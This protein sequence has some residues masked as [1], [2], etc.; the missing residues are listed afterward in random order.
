MSFLF[1][2]H[3]NE[4]T[5]TEEEQSVLFPQVPQVPQV[6]KV[7]IPQSQNV[8]PQ[9]GVP[10]CVSPKMQVIPA[11][12]DKMIQEGQ[13]LYIL[14]NKE[15]YWLPK[16][17][18]LSESVAEKIPYQAAGESLYKIPECISPKMSSDGQLNDVQPKKTGM[19]RR[20]ANGAGKALRV[21]GSIVKNTAGAA[22]TVAE[23]AG[24]AAFVGVG[25][26]VMA[27]CG[28]G[29]PQEQKRLSQGEQDSLAKVPQAHTNQLMEEPQIP[30][31]QEPQ[32]QEQNVQIVSVPQN[33]VDLVQAP[34]NQEPQPVKDGEMSKGF[35]GLVKDVIQSVS[36]IT[37]IV[38]WI[39]EEL[40]NISQILKPM[41]QSG[42]LKIIIK[43]FGTIGPIAKELDNIGNIVDNSIKLINKNISIDTKDVMHYEPVL[44]NA[45]NDVADDDIFGM[46]QKTKVS[47]SI[48]AS[49]FLKAF[50]DIRNKYKATLNKSWFSW[51][52]VANMSSLFIG[53]CKDLNPCVNKY[54]NFFEY[55]S[56]G[57]LS[58]K[59]N[60]K[61]L[62]C[63]IYTAQYIIN[64]VATIPCSSFKVAN[65][66]RLVKVL[67]GDSTINYNHVNYWDY[68]EKEDEN[69]PINDQKG[70]NIKIG[71]IYEQKGTADFP[72]ECGNEITDDLLRQKWYIDC[73]TSKHSL[74]FKDARIKIN[75]GNKDFEKLPYVVV[76]PKVVNRS[77]F[78]DVFSKY[79]FNDINS[80]EY[81]IGENNDVFK[82]S[83]KYV[84]RKIIDIY[85]GAY[86]QVLRWEIIKKLQNQNAGDS[87]S[88]YYEKFYS[89]IFKEIIEHSLI[90]QGVYNNVYSADSKV[91]GDIYPSEH[92]KNLYEDIVKTSNLGNKIK[93]NFAELKI[94]D[95]F[96]DMGNNKLK[97]IT[98]SGKLISDLLN[99][100]SSL[101]KHSSLMNQNYQ[102]T[103]ANPE[104]ISS[105]QKY[106]GQNLAFVVKSMAD[107]A[108]NIQAVMQHKV[109]SPKNG[110]G[111][112]DELF[113]GLA[114]LGA[115]AL[116]KY[117]KQNAENI[118]I[119]AN[120][121]V[122][123][124]DNMPQIIE[125]ASSTINEVLK[126]YREVVFALDEVMPDI[127][128]ILDDISES[129]WLF[130]DLGSIYPSDAKQAC[131]SIANFKVGELNFIKDII[132]ESKLVY[133]KYDKGDKENAYII[134]FSIMKKIAKRYS[135][136]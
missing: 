104:D 73:K 69:T 37:D 100:V 10:G 119:T 52:K 49:D 67:S 101:T 117:D 27:I 61:T 21:G 44:E 39:S 106:A 70:K 89:M 5:Q 7:Q 59:I 94:S 115:W 135:N 111:L 98:D 133:E 103:G 92:A 131:A 58:S 22:L 102:S 56:N 86:G 130:V 2:R 105:A 107:K 46:M 63:D 136:N 17:P 68:I 74:G 108:N 48:L 19:L 90:A 116:K 35:Q 60:N 38:S 75:N 28:E 1:K 65:I 97:A 29:V 54:I 53:V 87:L 99:F 134:L 71:E 8:V 16:T 14:R 4:K 43:L 81:I 20:L 127:E 113:K 118:D 122:A 34:V 3:K 41:L 47:C 66:I 124:V 51:T 12:V 112:V 121:I 76:F 6:V 26:G 32:K 72:L 110:I 42:G 91:K 79:G 45:Q 114:K 123:A 77:I 11:P 30:V 18:K 78:R 25:K 57:D 15:P 128:K 55:I 126:N 129:M 95:R 82:G 85:G 83:G 80:I 125:T 33:Q 96:K 88:D 36:I 93:G 84:R 24:A 64:N 40:K 132:N 109:H 31:N 13:A 50:V 120:T 23:V 62:L 9:I